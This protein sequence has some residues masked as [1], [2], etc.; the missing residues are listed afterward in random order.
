M[1]LSVSSCQRQ[2]NQDGSSL[3]SLQ[4]ID[5][6]GFNETIS[7][8]ERLKSYENRNYLESQPYKKVMRN[9][10][11]NCKGLQKTIVTS[12]HD[13]GQ[14]EQYLEVE[15][16]RARGEFKQWY[17]NGNLKIEA[18]VLEGIGD[19]TESCMETWVFD[20]Q[21]RAYQDNGRLEAI[22]SYEKGELS[23]ESTYFYPNGSLRKKTPFVKSK[24]HGTEIHYDEGGSEVG[25]FQFQNGKKEGKSIYQ[26]SRFCPK[27]EE[28]YS[29]ERLETGKYFDSK[30]NLVSAIRN[31]QGIQTV[32]LNGKLAKQY[33]FKDGRQSGKVYVYNPRGFLENEYFVKKDK[34]H[35][36]EWV[37]YPAL[38]TS[39]KPK[40]LLTWYEGSLHGRVKSWYPNGQLESEKEIQNNQ[41]NGVATAWYKNG[42][43][44]LIEEYEK[45]KLMK[46]SYRKIGDKNP[47]S[48]IEQGEG[49]AS[50]YDADG[51]FVKKIQYQKGLPVENQ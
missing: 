18:Q 36:E 16:G 40:L 26:G 41:K 51:F 46:G 11:K 10:E 2:D 34:K 33:E 38:E 48:K 13:N 45:D 20:G 28:F 5:R 7:T 44:M 49:F 24:I 25:F 19:L 14:I 47:V 35:G 32:Y 27:F 17:P 15:N 1:A 30:G 23:G 4:T 31:G 3:V 6:N 12:Y 21:C 39:K 29:A 50:I 42:S 9:F 43:L 37:Y 22:I 8:K